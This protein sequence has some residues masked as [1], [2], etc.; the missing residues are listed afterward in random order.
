MNRYSP[1][2]RGPFFYFLFMHVGNLIGV[3]FVHEVPI[4]AI[5]Q[6]FSVYRKARLDYSVGLLT[7]HAPERKALLGVKHCF[8]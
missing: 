8:R 4:V 6:S 3:S 1:R 5:F 7:K 2:Q